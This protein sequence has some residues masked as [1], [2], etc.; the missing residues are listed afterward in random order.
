[1]TA[2]F[3][4]QRD[5]MAA[6][7]GQREAGP[8]APYRR[9]ALASWRHALAAAYPV[10]ERLVGPAFFA[11]AADRHAERHPSASGD[12]HEYGRHFAAFLAG[13][14]HAA[15]L[16]YLP[17]VARLEWALHEAAFAAEAAPLDF[18]RLATLDHPG[19]DAVVLEWHPAVRILAS[20]HPIVALWEANQPGCDGVPARTEGED[21]VLV[22]RAAG[23]A[24]PHVL[25][26]DAWR[27]AVAI[28]A[29]TPLAGMVDAL[30]DAAPRL[31]EILTRFAAAGALAGFRL[32]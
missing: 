25:D 5:F 4:L 19:R 13:Y 9:Q 21:R 16:P 32:P 29:A 22:S 15:G 7:R 28:E 23:E 10:V 27:C 14:P 17:D 26:A 2:L 1:M 6:V 3:E 12:L 31:P 24:R 11:E 30:G 20:G 18:A 8:L